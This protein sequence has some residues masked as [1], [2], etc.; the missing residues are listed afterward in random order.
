MFLSSQLS[1]MTVFRLL[2]LSALIPKNM[3][4]RAGLID[5]TEAPAGIDKDR[6]RE[7]GHDK[8]GRRGRDRDR[9]SCSSSYSRSVIN[10]N[11]I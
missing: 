3:L 5:Y 4:P 6:S 7:R 10:I 9:E 8:N 1:G 2:G 11:F